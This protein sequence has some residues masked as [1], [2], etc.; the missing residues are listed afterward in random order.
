[1]INVLKQY[2]STCEAYGLAFDQQ[3][4]V[5][6]YDDTTLF[7]VA[8][9]QRYK[10]MFTNHIIKDITYANVQSCIRLND[11]DS[12]GDGVHYAAFDMLGLFSFRHWS[13]KQAVHF[14]HD[15]LAEIDIKPDYA[16]VHPKRAAWAMFHLDAGVEVKTDEDCTWSDG[17]IGG[18]CTEFYY[19][20]VEI[21]NIVN[22]MDTCIDCG[23][24]LERLDILANGTRRPTE[25]ESLAKC[26][27]KMIDSK[28][29][30]ENTG[31][32]YELRR[33]MRRLHRLHGHVDH[34]FF[35]HEVSRQEKVRERYNALKD[36]HKDKDAAWWWDTHGVRLEDV[37]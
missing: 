6:P 22:P 23:F 16:T 32:G 2:Q 12:L 5:L 31:Q 3:S 34:P 17:Q 33:V 1:M 27:L 35:R 24:G 18:F 8:G 10:R 36:K 13:V 15:Y 26:I 25:I 7:C 4:G 28:I 30:P 20:G 21:G 14:W 11:L 37:T 29:V 9:M 19:K